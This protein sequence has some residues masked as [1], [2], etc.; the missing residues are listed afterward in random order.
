MILTLSP[1]SLLST[2]EPALVLSRTRIDFVSY[3][4]LGALWLV[5]DIDTLSESIDTYALR[6]QTIVDNDEVEVGTIRVDTFL[7]LPPVFPYQQ[8]YREC[9]HPP[10]TDT[11]RTS[12]LQ[13]R[14]GATLSRIHLSSPPP[15]RIRLL[16]VRTRL[17]L[18]GASFGGTATNY[19][20]R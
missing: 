13:L 12:L 9:L 2:P 18:H 19:R 16:L 20:P 11:P 10:P 17:T 1:L 14:N 7:V 3:R 5:G 4:L 6:T 15:S 8:L